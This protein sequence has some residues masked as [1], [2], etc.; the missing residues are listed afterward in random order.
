MFVYDILKNQVTEMSIFEISDMINRTISNVSRSAKRGSIIKG[1]NIVIFKNE[2]TL[3][4]RRSKYYEL[5][6]ENE[7]WHTIKGSNEQFKISNYGR[8]KRVYKNGE[9]FLLPVIRKQCGNMV[10]K[11]RYL[12]IYKSYRVKDLVAAHFLRKPKPHEVLVHSNGIKTDDSAANLKWMDRKKV[13]QKTGAKSKSK[14]V[15]KLNPQTLEVL[16]E[17]RSSREAGRMTPYSYQAIC[18]YCNGKHKNHYG[19][20]FMWREEYEDMYGEVG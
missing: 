7:V 6:L 16:E 4:E 13:G 12:G 10:V 11:V 18:D 14:E 9:K 19:D 5:K 8:I 17:Y 2:P 3:E 1:L 20:L 15:V